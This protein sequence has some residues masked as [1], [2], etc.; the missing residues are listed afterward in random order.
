MTVTVRGKSGVLPFAEPLRRGASFTVSLFIHGAMLAWVIAASSLGFGEK[1]RPIY[2]QQIRP[3]ETKIVWYRLQTLLPNVRPSEAKVTPKPPRAVRRLDQNLIAGAKELPSPPQKVWVPD[4]PKSEMP[5]PK[6]EP[7]PNLLALAPAPRMP[8]RKFEP[9][10]PIPVKVKPAEPLPD[11]F[12]NDAA[13]Q[14]ALKQAAITPKALPFAMDLPRPVRAFI[15]P[16]SLPRPAAAPHE[17]LAA[18]PDVTP[19]AAPAPA[20]AI[21]GLDPARTMEIPKPPPIRD[22][23]FSAGPKPNPDGETAPAN[24]AMLSVPSIYASGGPKDIRTLNASD[25]GSVSRTNLLAA[26]RPGGVPRPSIPATPRAPHV[27]NSPDPRMNGRL[28]YMMA[29]QMPNVTSFS[30]SWMVWFA[31]HEPLPGGPPLDMRAPEPMHKVDPKYIVDAA[32]ERVEGI[33]RLTAV[34]RKDGSIDEVEL[35]KHLD[36]RLDRSAVEALAKWRFEPAQ[37][38]GTPVDVDA[39]FEIP[40][41]LAPRTSRED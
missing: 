38:D 12:A 34:I 22:A 37:R 19:L 25:L 18:P 3:N 26:I 35:L 32:N 21:V 6:L 9:P 17:D 33:V 31:E 36:D 40:F 13:P 14:A 15:P 23:G 11:V 8:L 10:P 1:P 27:S 39:V 16:P 41:R 4:P 20:M 30:G 24:T 7:L 28:I 5:K 2:D 29:I